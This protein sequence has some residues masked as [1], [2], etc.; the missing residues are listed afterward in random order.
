MVIIT[1]VNCLV[2]RESFNE[3]TF[4]VEDASSS[5]T[6]SSS[7][8]ADKAIDVNDKK[9][10]TPRKAGTKKLQAGTPMAGAKNDPQS[11]LGRLGAT[12]M[13]LSWSRW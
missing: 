13:K 10:K 6:S 7:E 1:T 12:G 11:L 5:E 2:G 9:L 8:N 4:V 3:G